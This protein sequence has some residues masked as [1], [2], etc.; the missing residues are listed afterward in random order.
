MNDIKAI[1]SAIGLTFLDKNLLLQA[2]THTTYA[3]WIGTPES[4]NEWLAI[5]VVQKT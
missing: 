1:E 4:H 3:R 2:L 5:L